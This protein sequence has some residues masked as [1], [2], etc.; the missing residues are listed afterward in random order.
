MKP[1][2]PVLATALALAPVGALALTLATQPGSDI[3]LK[4]SSGQKLVDVADGR[5]AAPPTWHIAQWKIPKDLAPEGAVDPDADWHL[6]NDYGEVRYL[7]ASGAYALGSDG[8][9]PALR[10]QD[11][12]DLLLEPNSR[13]EPRQA[14]GMTPSAPLAELRSVR[15]RFGFSLPRQEVVGKCPINYASYTAALVLTNPA[16]KQTLFYQFILLDSRG[17][18]RGADLYRAWC[19]DESA[20]EFCVDTSVA[21]FGQ[22]LPQPQGARVEYDFDVAAELRSVI[23]DGHKDMDRD[24]AHWRIGSLYLGNIVLGGAHAV[25]TWDSFS[26]VTSP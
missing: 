1:T 17:G 18:T 9:R 4:S 13:N 5:A 22:R 3:L 7:A 6:G 2:I 15:L 25:S 12:F 11:E 20:T 8:T 26:L 24:P 10:C 21:R 14:Q 16:H 23:A 19:P